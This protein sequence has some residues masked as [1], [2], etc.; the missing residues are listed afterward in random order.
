MYVNDKFDH[1]ECLDLDV[2]EKGFFESKFSEV[3]ISKKFNI[4]LSEIYRV[5]NTSETK[6]GNFCTENIFC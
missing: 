5:P 3:V 4:L 1:K 2:F 6:L